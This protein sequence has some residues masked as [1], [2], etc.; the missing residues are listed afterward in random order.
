MARFY[1]DF[2]DAAGIIRDN[3]GEELPSATVALKEAL[4]MVGQAVK[5]LTSRQSEGRIAVEV[6][7]GEG[8]VLKV[9]ATI[10]TTSL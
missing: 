6:R 5:D 4:E 10:E 9:S 1:F 2:Y 7:D 3:A 8:P